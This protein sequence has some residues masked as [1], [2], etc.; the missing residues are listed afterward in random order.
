M[1]KFYHL[2]SSFH[3]S[4]NSVNNNHHHHHHL[5]STWPS[6]ITCQAL[7]TGAETVLTTNI[8][9]ITISAQ[10]GSV[11]SPVKLFPLFHWSWNSV[12]NNH[13]HHHHLCST[14]L[15]SITCWA[16]FPWAEA[17]LITIIIIIT[18]Q[19]VK[20]LSP[21]ELCP[22]ELFHCMTENGDGGDSYFHACEDFAWMFDHSFPAAL[23]LYIFFS[24]Y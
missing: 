16:L 24:G 8:I 4:W 20:V 12:N 7:S 3:W 23:F 9:I 13:H 6:S 2:S 19:H 21:V 18:A 14:W 17:V 1:A 10:H 11:L 22:L 5:C 15:S